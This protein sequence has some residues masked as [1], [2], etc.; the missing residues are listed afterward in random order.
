VD[1]KVGVG[2]AAVALVVLL[3]HYAAR[4]V[5]ARQG[6]FVWLMFVP[7]LIAGFAIVW[8]GISIFPTV[9]LLGVAIAVFGGIK[10]VVVVRFIARLSRAVS[11]AG[12]DDE[13]GTAVTEPFVEFIRATTG[14]MLI[15]ALVG[16]V[17]LIV[18][19]VST[20]GR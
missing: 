18:L 20:G 16:L 19:A 1:W 8:A 6:R 5:R 10:V 11:S 15:G 3:R 7:T 14:L 2:I 9:P 13:V 12:S 17:A 4:R